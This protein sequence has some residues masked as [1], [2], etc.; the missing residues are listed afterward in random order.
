[1]SSVKPSNARGKK[2]T[3]KETVVQSLFSVSNLLCSV[4]LAMRDEI[5]TL[6]TGSECSH[7]LKVNWEEARF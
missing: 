2:S 4:W 6:A 5:L 3:K 7:C 1:M